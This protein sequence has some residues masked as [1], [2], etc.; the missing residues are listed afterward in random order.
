MVLL[1]IM[2][3]LNESIV[4]LLLTVSL[5]IVIGVN[6]HVVER[7]KRFQVNI[8]YFNIKVGRI[9]NSIVSLTSF[10]FLNCFIYVSLFD[11]RETTGAILL[12]TFTLNKSLTVM[13]ITIVIKISNYVDEYISCLFSKNSSL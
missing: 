13:G 3:I 12:G 4:T 7:K 5:V 9:A 1:V 6:V 10:I 11:S 2:I 8:N